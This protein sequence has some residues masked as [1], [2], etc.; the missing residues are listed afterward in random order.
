MQNA[1]GAYAERYGVA[2]MM[3]EHIATYYSRL[4]SVSDEYFWLYWHYST[5]SKGCYFSHELDANI[6]RVR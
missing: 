1:R 6:R 5:A 3:Y 2:R 4:K